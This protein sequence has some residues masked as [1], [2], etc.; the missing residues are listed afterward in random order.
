VAKT[1]LRV[2]IQR[3]DNLF[4]VLEDHPDMANMMLRGFARGISAMVE[5]IAAQKA[6][7]ERR[8][9]VPPSG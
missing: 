5:R 7:E 8:S 3:G 2:L 1:D 4:D 9:D 6:A